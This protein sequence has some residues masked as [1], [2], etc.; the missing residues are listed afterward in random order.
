[1]AQGL[2]IKPNIIS[3]FTAYFSP[4]RQTQ[5][6]RDRVV[7]EGID[8]VGG[9]FSAQE[10]LVEELEPSL[11]SPLQAIISSQLVK[12]SPTSEL[13]SSILIRQSKMEPKNQRI[14]V[15]TIIERNFYTILSAILFTIALTASLTIS[16]STGG[17]AVPFLA[18]AA[19]AFG[20]SFFGCLWGCNQNQNP[21]G[22][23]IAR[24]E[25]FLASEK[26]IR[27]S[28][29]DQRESFLTMPSSPKVSQ[30]TS[31]S[32]KISIL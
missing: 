28:D 16:F 29:S 27:E 26:N 19:G 2:S 6:L 9:L 4:M 20:V 18:A 7:P 1:M 10:T 32:R 15:G 8:V 12:P 21:K 23:D 13:K 30:R 11:P 3:R 31:S 14:S 25:P 17:L 5:S 24:Q 22:N